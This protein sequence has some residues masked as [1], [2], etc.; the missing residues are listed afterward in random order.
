MNDPQWNELSEAWRADGLA[1]KVRGHRRGAWLATIAE[2]AF[3]LFSIG[4]AVFLALRDGSLWIRIWAALIVV[5]FAVAL[6][7]ALWNRRDALWPSSEAPLD[8]LAGAEL[9]CRRRLELM[10]F[11]VR[12]GAAEAVLSLIIFWSVG[13]LLLGASLLALVCLAGFFWSR[14]A[15]AQVSRELAAIERLRQELG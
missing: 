8:F 4:V 13:P 11:M 10:T 7:Y 6:G 2:I 9:R 3:A 12:L 15:R 14:F 1:G 5:L